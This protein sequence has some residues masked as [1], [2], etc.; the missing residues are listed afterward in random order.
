[1][2]KAMSAASMS[3][4]AG[5]LQELLWKKVHQAVV[6]ARRLKLKEDLHSPG[7]VSR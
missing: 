7:I 6:R 5:C 4:F 3:R 1:M 2:I